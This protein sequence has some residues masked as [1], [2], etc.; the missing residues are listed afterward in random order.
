[1]ALKKSDPSDSRLWLT[2]L[3]PFRTISAAMALRKKKEY[4]KGGKIYIS[5]NKMR[6]YHWLNTD[7]GNLS[8]KLPESNTLNFQGG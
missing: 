6:Y 1:M 8:T 5:L 4:R 7:C 2:S 3:C